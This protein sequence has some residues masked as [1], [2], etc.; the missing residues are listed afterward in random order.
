MK[1]AKVIFWV[2]VSLALVNL[3]VLDVIV[4]APQEKREFSERL[5][6]VEERVKRLGSEFADLTS[7]TKDDQEDVV[8]V[9]EALVP[10]PTPTAIPS[11]AQTPTIE[12]KVVNPALQQIAKEYYVPLGHAAL[13]TE[14]FSWGDTGVETTLDLGNY[15]GVKEVNF[16]ATLYAPAGHVEARLYNVSDS[17]ALL[18]ST[19][20]GTT[21]DPKFYRSGNVVLPSGNKTYRVQMRT[22][23]HVVAQMDN[24]RIKIVVE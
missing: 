18:D 4:S 20:L 21:Q 6:A 17:N 22:S 7:G 19:I 2:L 10:S 12:K 24:A 14:N 5:D 16:D 1:L 11:K 23:L 9:G 15:P 13:A 8:E 3:L